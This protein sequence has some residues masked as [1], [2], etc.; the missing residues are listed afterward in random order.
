[1]CGLAGVV[2]S[3]DDALLE[4]LGASLR[5]RGPDGGGVVT[6]EDVALV[7]RRLAIIDLET[8]EQPMSD[9]EGSTVVVL[10]AMTPG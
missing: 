8:G 7:A 1:M 9:A 3:W 10:C 6:H 5:H 4:R 2:G